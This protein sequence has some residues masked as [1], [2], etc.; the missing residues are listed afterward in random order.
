MFCSNQEPFLSASMP[1]KIVLRKDTMPANRNP[2]SVTIQRRNAQTL[3][4]ELAWETTEMAEYLGCK[5][6]T[7][8]RNPESRNLQFKL[9]DLE[10]VLVRV[11]AYLPDP[12][13]FRRWFRQPDRDLGGR[14]L[15]LILEGKI[16]F[17]KNHLRHIETSQ[18]D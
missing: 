15:Q 10:S 16:Q 3:C 13:D 5:P 2:D 17:V 11:K 9:E 8:R 6:I 18:P 4:A 14:P 12:R 7:I 1:C